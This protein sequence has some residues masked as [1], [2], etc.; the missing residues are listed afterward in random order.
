MAK[1]G[2]Q[3]R[4]Y[5]TSRDTDSINPNNEIQVQNLEHLGLVAGIIDEMG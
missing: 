1:L 5:G 4:E 3:G 2:R